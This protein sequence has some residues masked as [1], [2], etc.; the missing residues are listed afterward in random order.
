[1]L[2]PVTRYSIFQSSVFADNFIAQMQQSYATDFDLNSPKEAAMLRKYYDHLQ[3][4]NT[5]NKPINRH[6]VLAYPA[7]SKNDYVANFS[8]TLQ[9]FFRELDISKI[10][11]M[12]D[13]CISI[14]EEFPFENFSK[15][16]SFK[17]LGGV[18]SG[19]VGYKIHIYNLHKVFPLFFFSRRYDVPVIFFLTA[20]G[21]TPLSIRL[22]DDGNLHIN[23]QEEYEQ[24][25]HHAA[26]EAGLKIG[27][28]ELCDAYSVVYFFNGYI[29]TQP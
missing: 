8:L 1:M 16:N 20:E 14:V 21:E 28:T 22:C 4:F 5:I 25:I 10:Y 9:H 13:T 24:H 19:Q 3:P 27:D 18:K 15:R 11:L 6:N 26:K 29:N 17:R 2:I 7:T 12:E 23:Y